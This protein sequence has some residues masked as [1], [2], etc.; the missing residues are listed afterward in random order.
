[1]NFSNFEAKGTNCN[2][3]LEETLHRPGHE[4]G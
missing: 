2:L 3:H 4:Y 1:M